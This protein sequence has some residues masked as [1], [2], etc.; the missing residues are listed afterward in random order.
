MPTTQCRRSI[1]LAIAAFVI[2]SWPIGAQSPAPGSGP[3]TAPAPP[4]TGSTPPAPASGTS[5]KAPAPTKAEA[6]EAARVIVPANYVIGPDDVLSV[7]FW[8][9]QDMTHDVVV[10]PDGKISLPVV[11]DL[12]AAGLTPDQLRE[13]VAKAATRL[14][15]DEPT[16]SIVVKQIN[17]RKV[18]ITGGINK[19]GAYPL[20]G[21]MTI[22]QLIALAGG[23][24]EYADKENISVVSADKKPDGT[25]M[26][27]KFDYKQFLKGTNL[28]QNIELK[29]GDTV[30][31]PL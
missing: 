5:T 27:Y 31:I 11:N 1:Y 25:P 24:V 2:C 29:P 16:V 4:S 18:Y 8:R 17:S 20:I 22:A 3:S 12:Q 10:R 26:R 13:S 23:L 14:Y 30:I 15:T 19:P 7:V 9:D 6:A 28:K 21:P